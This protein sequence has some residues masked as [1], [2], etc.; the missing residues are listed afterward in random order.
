MTPVDGT[1]TYSFTMYAAIPT[2][3]AELVWDGNAKEQVWKT[4]WEALVDLTRSDGDLQACFGDP[5]ASADVVAPTLVTVTPAEDES[6]VSKSTTV[7]WVFSEAIAVKDIVAEKFYLAANPESTG[8]GAYVAGALT[9]SSD[10]K[11]VTFT[12]TSALG[13]TTN[14]IAVATKYIHDTAGNAFAGSITAFVTT[15]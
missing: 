2:G 5:A 8:N 11:T 1:A 13:A 7:I 3:D 14:Y 15:S 9:Y 6:G 12:P 10:F 4:K